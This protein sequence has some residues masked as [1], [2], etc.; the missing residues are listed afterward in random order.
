MRAFLIDDEPL[1]SKRLAR[2]LEAS[3]RVEVVGS[4][5]DPVAAIAAIEAMRPDVIFLDIQMPE[6][7]GFE[8]LAR[9]Q[10]PP[11]VVFTTAYDNYALRAFEVNSIDYLL[12]PVEQQQ[13]DRALAKLEKMLA[14]PETRPQIQQML[15]QILAG[16]SSPP[17]ATFL[18]RISSRVGEV[19]EVVDIG[20][21][22]HFYASDKLTFAA[23]PGKNYVVDFT[24]QQ[25]EERLDPSQF[26]RIHRST[27]VATKA[28][29]ELH[30]WFAG[31]MRIRLKDKGHTELDVARERVKELKMRL[32]M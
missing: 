29:Q 26:V 28:V 13:L 24:I 16:L 27:I 31:R 9:L 3:Q 25:L 14:R 7:N 15:E 12:K 17:A 22:T 11:L 10:P 6:M 1:A 21:I 30:P 19:I 8:M 18:K 2:M 5:S 20:A 4:E 23:T 32:G